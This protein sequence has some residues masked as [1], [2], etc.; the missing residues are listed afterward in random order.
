M[1]KE[2][3]GEDWVYFEM[4]LKFYYVFGRGLNCSFGGRS[5]RKKNVLVAHY[6]QTN[7]H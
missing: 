6:L 4:Q 7:T 1:V 5:A 2:V 3:V